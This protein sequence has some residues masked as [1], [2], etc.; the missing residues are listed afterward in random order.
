MYLFEYRQ[1]GWAAHI[2]QHQLDIV[3]VKLQLSVMR[4]DPNGD[5]HSDS[6]KKEVHFHSLRVDSLRK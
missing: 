1:V 2:A 6:V 3:D 4:F 5:E